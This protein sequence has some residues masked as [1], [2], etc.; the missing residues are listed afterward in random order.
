MI[1]L[2]NDGTD[3]IT[4]DNFV[5]CGN[6]QRDELS[7]V[8]HL[9][10]GRELYNFLD[11]LNSWDDIPANVFQ[12]LAEACG[13]EYDAKEEADELMER[14]EKVLKKYRVLPKYIDLWYGNS[15]MEEIA[16]KQE[17]GWS[18]NEIKALARDWAKD[19]NELLDELEE[20]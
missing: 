19:E 16:E 3:Y 7:K 13:I 6:E 18:L 20:I 10:N 11:S 15:S 17:E 4:S 5:N 1:Y 2:N 8:Y 12:Q 14:C 9:P